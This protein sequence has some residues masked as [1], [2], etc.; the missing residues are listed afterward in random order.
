[1]KKPSFIW[2][3]LIVSLLLPLVSAC[4]GG[5]PQTGSNS[6]PTRDELYILDSSTKTG[7]TESA[8][9]IIALPMGTTNPTARLTLPAGLTDLKHQRVYIADPLPEANGSVHTTITALDTS[10]G[11]T[12]RTFTIPGNYSTADQGY[13]NSMLSGDGHWLALLAQHTPAGVT[14][15]ALL[16]TQAGRL[17]KSIHLNGDFTLDAVSPK[18][19][20]LYLLE[21]Y[22]ARDEPLQR[23]SL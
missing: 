10:S 20:M 14:S 17:V 5:L 18:G 15:I 8:Q 16:D 1:M 21:Y 11:A 3:G 9:H 22:Q 12:V 19:T 23:A 13:T 7:H 4:A 2:L 6:N